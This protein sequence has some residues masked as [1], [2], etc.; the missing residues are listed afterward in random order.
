M[1][2]EQLLQG[3]Y[4]VHNFDIV[5]NEARPIAAMNA[6]SF[7]V[8]HERNLWHQVDATAWIVEDVKSAKPELPVAVFL[9][10]PRNFS[11]SYERAK[12]LFPKLDAEIIMEDRLRT[13]ARTQT[14]GF[15]PFQPG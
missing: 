8:G 12:L 13:W 15:E 3:R 5:L 9:L 2:R 11:A 6:L 10:P 4:E 7:E 1:G 14:Q